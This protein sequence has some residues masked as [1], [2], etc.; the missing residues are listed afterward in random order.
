MAMFLGQG[1]TEIIEVTC[2]H[3]DCQSNESKMSSTF[4]NLPHALI[5]QLNRTVPNPRCQTEI[6]KLTNQIDI[7]IE[8]RPKSTGPLYI[9]T[10]ALQQICEEATPGH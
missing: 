7:P 3:G 9:L 10:G 8:Y 6:M 1:V 5:I 4:Q 2:G